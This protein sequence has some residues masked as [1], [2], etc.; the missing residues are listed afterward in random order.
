MDDL[1]VLEYPRNHTYQVAAYI[2]GENRFESADI[3]NKTYVEA[4]QKTDLLEFYLNHY[5]PSYT[6]NAR[7]VGIREKGEGGVDF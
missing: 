3:E 2:S 6:P 7:A 4:A 5:M 1:P